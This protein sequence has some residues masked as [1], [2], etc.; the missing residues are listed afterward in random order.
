MASRRIVGLSSVAAAAVLCGWGAAPAGAQLA[1]YEPFAYAPIGSD[2]SGKSGGGSFG[3]AAPWQPGGFNA[4]ISNHADVAPGS[5]SF[6]DL[7]TSGDRVSSTA[8]NA[9]AGVTR[10][11][12]TPLGD[13]G[14]T[15]YVSFLLRPEG[16]LNAG[17]FNGFLTLLFETAGEPELAIGK[18]GSGQVGRYMIESRG[19]AGQVASNVAAAVNQTS[20]LVVKAQ[21]TP[22]G[23]DVFTL[24]V[25]P[26]PGASEP[27][28][29]VTK[30]DANLGT[31]TGLTIYTSGAFSMDELRVG[32]TFADVTPVVPEPSGAA[33][34]AIAVTFLAGRRRRR[35]SRRG[36]AVCYTAAH[37]ER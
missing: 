19:G 30:A 25:N 1:A 16:T 8:Q 11:L 36:G 6:G 31:V 32:Q 5:L 13:A 37:G 29:G 27:A 3:F 12:S 26:T 2:L 4:S 22:G 24:Y 21:F 23:N 17:A 28:T 7:L 34:V 9:I 35:R 18:P 15:R 10:P 33:M 20:L 14:T